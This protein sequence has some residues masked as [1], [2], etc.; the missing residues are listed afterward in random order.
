MKF[1][2]KKPKIEPTGRTIDMTRRQWGHNVESLTWHDDNVSG[3]IWITP[4]PRPGDYIVWLTD[5]GSIKLLLTYVK[6]VG[7]VDDMYKFRAEIIERH[8]RG[9]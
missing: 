4:P 5:Y 3:F 9:S 7:N 8:Q 2:K 6:W 1:F